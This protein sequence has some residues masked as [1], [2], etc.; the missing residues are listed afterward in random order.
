MQDRTPHRVFQTPEDIETALT[1][2]TATL[3]EFVHFFRQW[4]ENRGDPIGIHPQSRRVN[5]GGR[6]LV[7]MSRLPSSSKTTASQSKTVTVKRRSTAVGTTVELKRG[8]WQGNVRVRHNQ[9]L[10]IT[11]SE[12]AMIVSTSSVV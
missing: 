1:Y 4:D 6:A 9:R 10:E 7:A 2:C 5:G 11:D 12:A 3:L 8:A